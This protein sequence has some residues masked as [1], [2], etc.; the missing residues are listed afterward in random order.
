MAKDKVRV[1]LA[2]CVGK[3]CAYL[4][5][6]KREDARVWANALVDILQKEGLL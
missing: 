5:V 1:S 6:G 3:I 4:A 2:R